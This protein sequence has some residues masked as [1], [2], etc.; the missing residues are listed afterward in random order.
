MF[1][2]LSALA[3]PALNKLRERAEAAAEEA[4]A[5]LED[6]QQKAAEEL[7]GT[8]TPTAGEEESPE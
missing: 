4:R 8:K 3:M 5:E 7:K 6:V 1:I 2:L